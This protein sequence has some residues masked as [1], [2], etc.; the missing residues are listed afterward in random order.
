MQINAAE[1]RRFF[2]KRKTVIHEHLRER[3]RV[4]RLP[5][6]AVARHDAGVLV[7]ARSFGQAA[8]RPFNRAHL[9]LKLL[10]GQA[11]FVNSSERKQASVTPAF[12]REDPLVDEARD[13]NDARSGSGSCEPGN[14][15]GLFRVC[16]GHNRI[17]G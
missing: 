8:Q 11:L 4:A 2:Q 6:Q 7:K 1:A 16:A 13:R 9:C 5:G 14:E 12:E 17:S 3:V 15:L 10:V